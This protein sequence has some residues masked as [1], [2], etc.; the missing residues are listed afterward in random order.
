MLSLDGELQGS[1]EAHLLSSFMKIP[2]AS[3]KHSGTNYFKGETLKQ[4]S[5]SIRVLNIILLLTSPSAFLAV[6]YFYS[7]IIA[8]I[9]S[10]FLSGCQLIVAV[11]GFKIEHEVT[12]ASLRFYRR[13]TKSYMFLSLLFVLGIQVAFLTERWRM[14]MANCEKSELTVICVERSGIL[15]IDI[16]LYVLFP[17]CD[18][19]LYL[20]TSYASN[21]VT[22]YTRRLKQ[23]IKEDVWW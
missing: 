14:Q 18:V 7:S 2:T 20:F 13:S 23:N 4:V 21:L 3:S 10:L 11:C 6:Y 12:A 5:L 17:C 19:L 15:S 22:K 16:V 9:L 8:L 1:P